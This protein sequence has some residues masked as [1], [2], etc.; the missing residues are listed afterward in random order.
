[1]KNTQK[2]MDSILPAFTPPRAYVVRCILFLAV[3]GFPLAVL[4]EQ[5]ITFFFQNPFLNVLILFTLLLGIFHTLHQIL[6]LNREI[7][8]S[9]HT[10]QRLIDIGD[11]DEQVIVK[12]PRRPNLLAPLA[13]L[14]E[15][16]GGSTSSLSP[17]SSRFLLDSIATRMNDARSVS[18]YLIGLLIFLGLLG[19]FWGLLETI[20]AI[21]DTVRSLGGG[22]GDPVGAFEELRAGLEA[23]LAGMGTAF[24]SSLFGLAGSLV[25]GFLDL[26]AGQ[27]QGRFYNE[28][29]EFVSDLT[30]MET[31]HASDAAAAGKPSGAL[32]DET[33]V[34]EDI[35]RLLMVSEGERALAGR[36]LEAIVSI[37]QKAF[38]P[39]GEVPGKPD[40]NKTDT[41]KK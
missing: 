9:R 36:N 33:H 23:P 5:I 1:M 20:T 17:T 28:L 31:R 3:L 15:K 13:A 24:S 30:H 2:S 25:L 4:S 14:L 29:E 35:R 41:K 10:A 40:T 7:A 34:L 11:D 39:S 38:P 21:G 22:A 12:M 6:R 32:A 16:S 26:Q 27:A 8:W 37:L 18:R 19:T